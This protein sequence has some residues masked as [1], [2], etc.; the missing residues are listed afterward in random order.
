[1]LRSSFSI[2][3]ELKSKV[4]ARQNLVK[5]PSLGFGLSP[6]RSNNFTSEQVSPFNLTKRQGKKS[7]QRQGE[8]DNWPNRA[9]HH[10][11]EGREQT[12]RAVALAA[13]PHHALCL[14][15]ETAPEGRA[16]ISGWKEP[17]LSNIH[18]SLHRAL[19]Q[20]TLKRMRCFKP[21][22][23]LKPCRTDRDPEDAN[24]PPAIPPQWHNFN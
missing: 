5:Q 8:E 17:K 2:K 18:L 14:T 9:A 19:L 21:A 10:V 20:S 6:P 4:T 3:P 16:V 15:R 1:M 12:Q 22:T 11:A 24:Q 7:L 13:S 23:F